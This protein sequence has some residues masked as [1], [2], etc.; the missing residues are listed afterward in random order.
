MTSSARRSLRYT[1]HGQEIQAHEFDYRRS[2]DQDVRTPAQHPIV[3]VGA[4]PVGLTLAIDLALEGSGCCCWTTTSGCLR[5]R[6]R[7]ALPSARWRSGTGSAWA[8]RWS[9]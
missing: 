1:S 9:P 8:T 6:A 5:D 3:L 2:H 7:S 4:G